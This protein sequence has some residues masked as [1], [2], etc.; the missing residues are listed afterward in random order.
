MQCSQ[1]GTN[2]DAGGAEEDVPVVNDT[3]AGPTYPDN[4]ARWTSFGDRDKWGPYN[5]HDP[6]CIAGEEWTYCFSTDVAYGGIDRVGLQ[7]RRSKDLVDWEFV[8][9]AFDG[10]PHEPKEYVTQANN[11][12]EPG[13]IWAPYIMKAGDTYRLYYS[14]SVFGSSGSCIALATSSSLGGDWEQQGI[15][16]KSTP[17]D[18]INAI[19]PSVIVDRQTGEH[20]MAYGSWFSGLY[21]T[22]LDPATGKPEHQRAFGEAIAR[23]AGDGLEAPEVIYND[24]T[25]KYYLFVSYGSLDDEY[26]VRVGRSDRPEGPYLDMFGTDMAQ[27]SDNFPVLLTPYGF[28]SHPGWQGT[29]HTGVFE[30]DGSWFMINQGRLAS[31]PAMMVMHLR[32]LTWTEDGWP[33]AYPQRYA[34]IEQHTI[35]ADSV[36]GR[37]EEIVID[38]TGGGDEQNLSF[39]VD[40]LEGGGIEGENRKWELSGDRLQLSGPD[41]TLKLHLKYGWDWESDT[42]ALIYTGL[43]Q[44]GESVW[45]KKVD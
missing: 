4:Y 45:G 26:N 3:A 40:Y 8:G 21:M 2:P 25:G 31:D 10:I 6:S 9:W 7:V 22:Q 30:K 23:R 19:D 33:A 5:V 18:T 34:D 32:E 42:T 15:V 20:W 17:G 35:T 1:Q 44:Q 38:P 36:V 27:R 16:L 39:Y 24:S 29:G 37:W 28:N 12:T 41:G 14:V 13:N 11:G 43:N